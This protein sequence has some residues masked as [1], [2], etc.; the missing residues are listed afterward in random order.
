MRWNK[1]KKKSKRTNIKKKKKLKQE[2]IEGSCGF[3]FFFAARP[4]KKIRNFSRLFCLVRLIFIQE[5]YKIPIV[6]V[7]HRK[8][9][10]VKNYFLMILFTDK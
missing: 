7:L 8:Q 3:F 2:D 5:Y 4:K 9:R 1:T 10:F 6:R